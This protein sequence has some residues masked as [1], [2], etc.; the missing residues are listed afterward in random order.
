M[1]K[2]FTI[3]IL[4]TAFIFTDHLVA[5]QFTSIQFTPEIIES[6]GYADI[7]ITAQIPFEDCETLNL[8]VLNACGAFAIEAYYASW[9]NPGDCYRTDT[10]TVGPFVFGLNA[11]TIDMYY[12]D[13]V[14]ADHF[15]TII[16]V[17]TITSVHKPQA[18]IAELGVFPNPASDVIS[19]SI[20]GLSPQSG[21]SLRITD[22]SGNCLLEKFLNYEQAMQ[23]IAIPWLST[24]I[25]VVQTRLEDNTARVAKLTVIRN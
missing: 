8:N 2:F 13:F 12:P 24:G 6:G 19:L 11:I 4:F 17:T 1:T 22:L 15:D 9:F 20:P 3:L 5:Q 7:V 21:V 23:P 10:V 16:D 18:Q 25:Y 14:Q